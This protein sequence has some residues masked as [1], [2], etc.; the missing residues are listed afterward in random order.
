MQG[1]EK[2]TYSIFLGGDSGRQLDESLAIKYMEKL[3][4]VFPGSKDRFSGEKAIYNWST[5]SL[6]EGSY[7]AYKVGQWTSIAGQEKTPVD[8]IF[9]AGE[10]CSE[11]FQGYMNGGAE[12]GRLAAEDVIKKVQN[13]KIVDSISK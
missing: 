3:E 6:V 11:D 7:S 13:L 2:S 12:S 4:Q 8:N 5:S 1:T 10:H 9:F